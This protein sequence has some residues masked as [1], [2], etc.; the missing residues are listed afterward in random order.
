MQWDTQGERVGHLLCG[1]EDLQG[2]LT[3]KEVLFLSKKAGAEMFLP[4]LQVSPNNRLV[5]K[6]SRTVDL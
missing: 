4:S 1:L 2:L 3:L 6:L 5:Q